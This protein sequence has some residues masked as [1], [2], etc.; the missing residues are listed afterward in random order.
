MLQPRLL[1]ATRQ[2]AAGQTE[3]CRAT[4]AAPE[5]LPFQ[6]EVPL[7]VLRASCAMEAGDCDAATALADA[8]PAAELE[9]LRRRTSCSPLEGE[10]AARVA[11]LR[12]LVQDPAR[13]DRR[14]RHVDRELRALLARRDVPIDAA[15][16]EL[17]T[18]AVRCWGRTGRCDEA[19]SLA[20]AARAALV[21]VGADGVPECKLSEPPSF[22]ID[23][24]A[25]ARRDADRPAQR[26]ALL[27]LAY[28]R[29]QIPELSFEAAQTYRELVDAPRAT[30]RRPAYRLRAL[31]LYGVY[32]ARRPDGVHRAEAAAQL[33]RL[34][35][36]RPP[37]GSGFTFAEPHVDPELDRALDVP[38][39]VAA[40]RRTIAARDA[41]L[42]CTFVTQR[43]LRLTTA[44][45]PADRD[46]DPAVACPQ[47]APTLEAHL[48]ELRCAE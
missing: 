2:L 41:L 24:L 43:P 13:R 5:L 20:D 46:D 10:P 9:A 32:L 11:A 33:R 38:A 45:L 30:E 18:S 6:R 31:A 23:Y 47:L 44:Q 37:A 34:E 42:L 12:E 26:A 16:R 22:A 48:A 17:A 14:C 15:L 8:V 7:R 39:G 4:L 35:D 29:L 3:A 1:A 36:M 28:A 19:R 25:A 21:L 40:C 27:E